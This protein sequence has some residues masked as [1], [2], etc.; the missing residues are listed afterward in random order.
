MR[1][2][3]VGKS[4]MLPKRHAVFKIGHGNLNIPDFVL[5]SMSVVVGINHR[6]EFDPFSFWDVRFVINLCK[7][8]NTVFPIGQKW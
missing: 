1:V 4:R 8:S 5:E 6:L 2:V 7:V 3:K